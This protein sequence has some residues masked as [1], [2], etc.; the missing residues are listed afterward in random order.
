MVDSY[1]ECP[2]TVEEAVERVLSVM[3]EED[4]KG[5]RNTAERDLIGLHFSLGMM[6]REE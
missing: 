5:L 6:I 3:S 1:K 4:K 2:E